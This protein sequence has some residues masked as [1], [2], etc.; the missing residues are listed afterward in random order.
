MFHV[1]NDGY[2]MLIMLYIRIMSYF[3]CEFCGVFCKNNSCKFYLNSV[4]CPM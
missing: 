4:V 1:N 2:S 3:V